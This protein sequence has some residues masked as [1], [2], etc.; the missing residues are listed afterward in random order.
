MSAGLIGS[1]YWCLDVV[2]YV[3]CNR[4]LKYTEASVGTFQLILYS[5]MCVAPPS[6]GTESE[7][8]DY[9]EI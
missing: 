1:A 4:E 6:C 3:V 9:T 5:S 2:A 8:K 7:A